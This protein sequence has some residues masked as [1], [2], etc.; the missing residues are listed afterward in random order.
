ML[1]QKTQRPDTRRAQP[2]E[3]SLLGDLEFEQILYD[4]LCVRPFQA[5]AHSNWRE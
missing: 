5:S 1:S 2:L 4:N 3:V